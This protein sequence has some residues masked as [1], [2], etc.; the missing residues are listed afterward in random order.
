MADKK[1]EDP[2][3]E[4]KPV[5]I[6]KAGVLKLLRDRKVEIVGRKGVSEQDVLSFADLGDRVNASPTFSA[7]TGRLKSSS[8][9]NVSNIG[10]R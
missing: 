3:T 4:E 10:R 1:N 5:G 6:D 2:K 7:E 8:R 9:K